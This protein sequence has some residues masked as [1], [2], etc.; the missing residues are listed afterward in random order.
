MVI[1]R[2]SVDL[3]KNV[4]IAGSDGSPERII[5]VVSDN[6]NLHNSSHGGGQHFNR[7]I[8]FLE[9]LA[10]FYEDFLSQI[11]P[12]GD[13]DLQI[14]M[15]RVDHEGSEI[16][17]L[18]GTPNP[19]VDLSLVAGSVDAR[20]DE[21]ETAISLAECG[22]ECSG[23]DFNSTIEAIDQLMDPDYN[24][25]IS[26]TRIIYVT[27]GIPC[28]NTVNCSTS[29]PHRQF[30]PG[31]DE[32]GRNLA[33]NGL[34]D[35]TYVFGIGDVMLSLRE[36]WQSALGPAGENGHIVLIDR[37]LT[38]LTETM[39]QAFAHEFVE[40]APTGIEIY[41][42][43]RNGI[44]P[45]RQDGSRTYQ[46]P[47]LTSE[48]YFMPIVGGEFFT[49]NAPTG[50]HPSNEEIA[51]TDFLYVENPCPGEWAIFSE[52]VTIPGGSSDYDRVLI[53]R[54]E[55]TVNVVIPN[56]QNLYFENV[57]VPFEIEVQYDFGSS[58]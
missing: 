49:I 45:P 50:C 21:W 8:P 36:S 23:T 35:I 20:V 10:R 37:Y 29:G 4:V 48:I 12:N 53:W 33:Q 52:P 24:A 32:F 2:L 34:Q 58:F 25:S 11:V 18:D 9:Y 28:G 46:V 26:N 40:S 3:P 6:R 16:V 17:Y 55:A 15:I 1:S 38:G 57:L 30:I 22:V 31:V 51:A 14:A 5:I 56:P 7:I 39:I 42:I 27:D 54:S 13:A 44:W 43:D 41:D 47:A 19:W